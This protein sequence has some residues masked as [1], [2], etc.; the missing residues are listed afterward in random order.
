MLLC[1]FLLRREFRLRL[2]PVAIALIDSE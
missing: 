2:D 1:L